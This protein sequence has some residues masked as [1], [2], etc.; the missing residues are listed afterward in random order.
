MA[1]K[2]YT[3]ESWTGYDS[4]ADETVADEGIL[5]KGSQNVLIDGDG[6]IYTRDGISE[7]KYQE[8]I[9]AVT[10]VDAYGDGSTYSNGNPTNASFDWIIP[11]STDSSNPILSRIRNI[12]AQNN[13]EMHVYFP[14]G[15]TYKYIDNS[16]TKTETVNTIKID[17]AGAVE[18]TIPTRDARLYFTP[19]YDSV[20]GRNLVLISGGYDG[21]ILGW[22]GAISTAVFKNATTVTIN[23]ALKNNFIGV[24]NP[25]LSNIQRHFLML[26]KDGTWKTFT[27]TNIASNGDT[28]VQQDP[29][30][31][32]IT[33]EPHLVIQKPFYV[34]TGLTDVYLDVVK[35]IDSEIYYGS[36]DFANQWKS[37]KG[38]YKTFT[39][40]TPRAPG[41]GIIMDLPGRFCAVVSQGGEV[42][43][44]SSDGTFMQIKRS[45]Y[46]N[47]QTS[48]AAIIEE[49]QL[50]QIKAGVGT[51]VLNQHMVDNWGDLLVFMDSSR[52]I[53]SVGELTD[54]EPLR[55]DTISDAIQTE[56]N[57]MNIKNASLQTISDELFLCFPEENIVFIREYT[58]NDA[59]ESRYYWQ[60][61]Q[62]FPVSRVGL[63]TINTNKEDK[64]TLVCHMADSPVTREMFS[65]LSDIGTGAKF[66]A[67]TSYRHYASRYYRKNFDTFYLEGKMNESTKL[68]IKNLVEFNGESDIRTKEVDGG[69]LGMSSKQNKLLIGDSI[70]GDKPIGTSPLESSLKRFRKYFEWKTEG[71]FEFAEEYS[72][73]GI[74]TKWVIFS[75]GPN[76]KE[77]T[78]IANYIKD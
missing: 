16:V 43:I 41:D 40:S 39:P 56:L 73:E 31:D 49:L 72:S 52:R 75:A 10:S 46:S 1:D 66:I 64:P 27:Y 15:I 30:A 67:K 14:Q 22:S 26:T 38:Y 24:A 7:T 55:I 6:K 76:A 59:G 62:L 33:G 4:S 36:Y 77:D 23:N 51:S 37:K 11:G 53:R 70:L 2:F 44:S 60:P 57:D 45:I 20:M 78:N 35:V 12:T 54:L 61:P 25:E 69:S 17:L 18:N 8:A 5:I 29:T 74:G 34:D 19:Y 65:G 3:T 48:G 32:M 58:R 9:N 50:K 63:W 13:T 68:Q 71:A 21:R 47:G 42:A 28:T